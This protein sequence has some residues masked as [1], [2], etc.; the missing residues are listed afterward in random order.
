MYVMISAWCPFPL[1]FLDLN[2]SIRIQNDIQ[3]IIYMI[4]SVILLSKFRWR[5]AIVV[6]LK[7]G[8]SVAIKNL[9]WKIEM[10]DKDLGFPLTCNLLVDL[11]SIIANDNN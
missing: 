9:V 3:L 2:V 4:L 1:A 5:N 7:D 8:T 10:K 6:Q 11:N